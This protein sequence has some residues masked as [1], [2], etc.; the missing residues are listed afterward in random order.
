[1]AGIGPSLKMIGNHL[2]HQSASPA[3]ALRAGIEPAT[4]ALTA[5]RTTVVLPKNDRHWSS[6]HRARGA[7]RTRDFSFTKRALCRAE[8]HGQKKRTQAP[9]FRD[10]SGDVIG[11]FATLRFGPVVEKSNPTRPLS[12]PRRKSNPSL[13]FTKPLH[14]RRAARATDHLEQVTEIESVYPRWQRGAS[15]VGLTCKLPESSQHRLADMP[16][17]RASSFA[18]RAPERGARGAAAFRRGDTI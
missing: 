17:G 4:I 12:S 1:M 11:R 10:L 7:N 5:R 9:A 3:F 18:G 16:R 6:S 15:P 8:L 2:P 13:R 14:D